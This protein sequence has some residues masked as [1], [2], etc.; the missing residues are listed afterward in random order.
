MR[1]GGQFVVMHIE[2]IISTFHHSFNENIAAL[3]LTLVQ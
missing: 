3:I 1:D 2:E